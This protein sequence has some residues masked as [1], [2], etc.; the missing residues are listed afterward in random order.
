VS[1]QRLTEPLVCGRCSLH[2]G[3]A[4]H[5][6][7]GEGNSSCRQ[8]LGAWLSGTAPQEPLS[9]FGLGVWNPLEPRSPAE[10]HADVGV[11]GDRRGREPHAVPRPPEPMLDVRQPTEADLVQMEDRR[12]DAL[13]L[14]ALQ[15]S[16][17]T[18]AERGGVRRFQVSAAA[19][20]SSTPSVKRPDNVCVERMIMRLMLCRRV[21]CHLY[22]S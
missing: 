11:P 22:R 13:P 10:Y 6:P 16:H 7:F 20:R 15:P 19:V 21:L 2:K 9:Q 8:S 3:V 12:Q 14:P 5:P 1:C 4:R 18:T 17:G